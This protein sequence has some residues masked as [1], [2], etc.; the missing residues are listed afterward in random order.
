MKL[1][2]EQIE[3]FLTEGWRFLPEVFEKYGAELDAAAYEWFG[4]AYY[5]IIGRS[6]AWFPSP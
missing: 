5:R 1:T 3:R 6:A 2:A 4:L